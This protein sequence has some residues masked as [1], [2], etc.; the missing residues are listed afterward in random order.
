MKLETELMIWQIDK[1]KLCIILYRN[2]KE[3]DNM[4]ERLRDMEGGVQMKNR[5]R[6]RESPR[7]SLFLRVSKII[8]C[9]K[10]NESQ[11]R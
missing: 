2:R 3:M 4:G 1:K 9:R 5:E 6:E 8:K 10:P 7:S 11:G